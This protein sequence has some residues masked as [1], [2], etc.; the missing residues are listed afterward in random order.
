MKVSRTS[1]H[2][3]TIE[4]N[5]GCKATREYEDLRYTKPLGEGAFLACEKHEKQ[6]AL[7]EFIGETM[8]EL[9]D[10]EAETAGKAPVVA[11]RAEVTTSMSG[12]ST[13]GGA[14]TSLGID[15]N[16]IKTRVPVDPLK[17]HTARFDRPD[18][19][20]PQ[21]TSPTGS[22]NVAGH[23]D[24]TDEEMQEAGITMNG[25]IDDVPEDPNT[26]AKVA[27][28]LGDLESI[29]DDDDVRSS[30]VSQRLINH[31]AAD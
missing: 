3:L 24:L 19:R 9:L 13:D 5:C 11:A 29:L 8:I 18:M 17:Q 30:G 6:K 20:R 28:D 10:K 15:P 4:K 1:V 7:I 21:N 22:L 31:Q 27:E 26:S 14:V 12:T 2:R 16:T 23:E 25:S